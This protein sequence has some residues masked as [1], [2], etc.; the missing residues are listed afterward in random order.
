MIALGLNLAGKSLERPQGI[1]SS[2]STRQPYVPIVLEMASLAHTNHEVFHPHV[3]SPGVLASKSWPIL[4]SSVV[5]SLGSCRHIARNFRV[6][7]TTGSH[8][9]DTKVVVVVLL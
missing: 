5:T 6:G 9:L 8:P 3:R 1:E 2:G 4:L 7:Y